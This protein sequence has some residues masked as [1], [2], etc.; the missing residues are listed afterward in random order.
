MPINAAIANAYTRFTSRNDVTPGVVDVDEA[1]QLIELAGEVNSQSSGCCGLF[2]GTKGDKSLRQ[3]LKEPRDK[4]DPEARS[5]ITMWLNNG[6]RLPATA[7]RPERPDPTTPV[8]PTNPDTPA[9]NH[10][11]V[12]LDWKSPKSTWPCHW[13]PMKAQQPGGDPMNNL[14]APNGPLDKYRIAFGGE[15]LAYER[16]NHAGGD[17]WFGHCNNAAQVASVLRQ[18]VK[19]VV[20]NGVTFTAHDI[21]GLL[22]KVVPSL[23]VKE[24]D[25][26]GMRYN[27]ANDDPS[28]PNP[29]V[30]LKMLKD[31]CKSGEGPFILDIDRTVQVW[32]YPFDQAKVYESDKAPTGFN[33]AALPRGGKTKFYRTELK[34]TGYPQQERKYQFWIQYDASGQPTERGY[35]AGEDEK[36]NADFGWR[37][38]AVGNLD[39]AAAWVTNGAQSNPHVLAQNVYKLYR[40]SIA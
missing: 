15:A 19:D 40:A 6:H 20:M 32:N 23:V 4:F 8:D 25:F 28:E 30:F 9:V 38:K 27:G 5:L 36:I 2:G 1:K 22:C 24:E 17:A 21:S 7:T 31:F 14:Y 33:P 18:P 12:I 3:L 16:A 29:V 39:N 34:G 11:K 10:G 13:W 26:T 37:A 35:V